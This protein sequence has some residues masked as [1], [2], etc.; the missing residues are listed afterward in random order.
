MT[1]QASDKP[2][3]PFKR[4]LLLSAGCLSL[5]LG[6]IGAFVPLLPTT[7]F[8]LAAAACFSRSSE[9]C[10]NWM[11]SNRWFGRYL[12][13]YRRHR[14]IP[15]HIQVGSLLFLWAGIGFSAFL[16][17]ESPWIRL[18]LLAVAAAVSLHIAALRILPGKRSL[19][20]TNPLG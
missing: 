14:A 4:T 7:C 5:A 17:V 16:W 20:I 10:H 8:L 12:S 15:R 13:D 6:V 1:R 11:T 2:I 3:H 19:G 9:R 18:L